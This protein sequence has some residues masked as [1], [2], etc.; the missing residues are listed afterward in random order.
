VSTPAPHAVEFDPLKDKSYQQTRLGASVVEFLAWKEIGGAA[1]GTLDQYERDLARGCLMYPTKGLGEFGDEEMIHVAQQFKDKERRVRVA[2][3]RSFFKWALRRR[4][5]TQNPIDA[6]PELKR[7]PQRVI[8]VFSDE[9][10]DVLVGLPLIDGALMQI[11]F[12]AGFR[13]SE[14]RRFKLSHFKPNPPPGQVVILGGKGGKDRVIPATLAVSQRI[15][16]LALVEGLKPSDHLWYAHQ[17]NA[18]FSRVTRDKVIGDG[19]FDRWWRRCID[20]AGVPYRNP[21]VTRHTFATRW[22]RRGG[23]L[24]TLAQAMGHTS[25]RTTADLYAHLDTR[26]MAADLVLI[27]GGVGSGENIP[28][29]EG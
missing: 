4:L 15:N 22:L 16:E 9:E 13:K 3:Y 12:D 14:A 21:H 7:Q 5:I 8:D 18:S 19:S 2:A 27:Q 1:E 25:I 10:I 24:I 29:Q 11:L 6:L 26:D 20:E 23:Q 17:A 28:E